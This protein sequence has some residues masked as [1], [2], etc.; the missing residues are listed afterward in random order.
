MTRRSDIKSGNELVQ[1][2]EKYMVQHDRLPDSGDWKALGELGF[3]ITETGTRPAYEKLSND[4]FQLIYLE[5]FDGPYLFYNSDSK[6][7]A[8]GWP[9]IPHK[10]DK[11]N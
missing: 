1:R 4:E 11:T 2:L 10:T 7:W 9:H 6:K 3:E 8:A 5:G